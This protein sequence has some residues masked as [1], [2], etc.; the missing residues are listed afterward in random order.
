MKLILRHFQSEVHYCHHRQVY[1]NEAHFQETIK[2][3]SDV[4]QSSNYRLHLTFEWTVKEECRRKKYHYKI[5]GQ[6]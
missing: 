6:H 5:Y 2:P 3:V 4:Y 1:Y